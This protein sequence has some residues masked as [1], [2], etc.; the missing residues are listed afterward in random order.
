[1]GPTA[2]T[3]EVP[4]K[5]TRTV[6][7][8]L[9][10]GVWL[11]G[12]ADTPAP[13]EIIRPVRTIQV[14]A[15]S[16]ARV[17]NFSGSARAGRETDLSFRVAGR[18]ELLDVRVGDP[19]RA[20][21]LVGRLEPTDFEIA[22]RRAHAGLEEA[23]AMARKADADLQRVRG[24]W[25]NQNASRNDLD[26]ALAG[27][28]SA[29]A[30]VDG[31]QQSLQS[32]QRQLGFAELRAPVAG[33]IAEV[34]V[35]VSENVRQGQLV[36]R[37]TSGSRPEVE[38]AIPEVLIARIRKGDPVSVTFDAIPGAALAAVVTEVGVAAT[39]G[40]T[41]FPVKVRLS[42]ARQEVRSGM[43]A[44]VTFE[45]SSGEGPARIQLPTHAVGEDREGR[46]VFVAEPG[47]DG[48]T[49]VRRRSV[50]VRPQPTADG[51]EILEGLSDGE[52]VVT[53]GVSRI[54]DG[55]TVRLMDPN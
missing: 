41:T 6:C 12:C 10:V 8:T 24:L 3:N 18:I 49:R 19:V 37:M 50:T 14:Y 7:L 40:S 30:R 35:E 22:V 21:Q 43:A 9:W 55:Q 17:R 47:E 42:E 44:R 20:G 1:M 25:E 36:A 28:S 33:A 4:V 38:V 54:V 11:I 5:R 13:T 52:R 46:F 2:A 48:L 16:V 51:L 34:A 53:A 23:Q 29:R 45:F 15:G 39:G 32:A 31:A 26:A 27:G